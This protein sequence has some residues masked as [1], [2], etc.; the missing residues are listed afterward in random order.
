MT[1]K[2]KWEP[3]ETA[4]EGECEILIA[5]DLSKFGRGVELQVFRRLKTFSGFMEVIGHQFASDEETPFAW[6]AIDP[7]DVEMI[8][9]IN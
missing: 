6:A 1:L 5:I 8:P 7:V 4:P 9:K 2:M 3:W